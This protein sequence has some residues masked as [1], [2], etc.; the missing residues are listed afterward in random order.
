ML[1]KLSTLLLLLTFCALTYAQDGYK[2]S[3]KLDNYDQKELYLGYYFGDKQY[4]RDTVTANADGAFVF[5]NKTEKLDAGMYLVVMAPDNKYF[6][7]MVNEF[8]QHFSVKT[9]AKNP[10]EKMEIRGS[11][12]NK[13]FYDYLTYLGEQRPIAETLNK[14]IAEATDENVKKGI[15]AKLEQ[16]NKTVEKYQQDIIDKNPLTLTAALIKVNMSPKVPE[17][18]GEDKEVKRWRW[19]Q[20][21]YFDQLDL[22]DERMIRT[23]FLFQRVNNYVEKMVIQNPDTIYQAVDMILQKVQPA[24]PTFKFFLVHFLNKYASAKIVGMDAVYVK[25]AQDYYAKG[26]APW[27]EEEQLTKIVDNAN[28]LEP[29]LIGK[30]APDFKAFE[31]DIPATLKA[32]ET[33]TSEHKKFKLSGERTLHGVESPYTVLVFWASDCGHCKKAM[34]GLK[35]FYDEYKTKGIEM[36][37]VCTK[38]YKDVPECAKLLDENK[39]YDWINIVDPYM[40]SKMTKTY[41]VR[42]TPQ[43]YILDKDKEII[44]KRIGTEQLPEVI[45]QILKQEEEKA[46][47]GK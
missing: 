33:E 22:A 31:L 24:E 15:Q 18:T 37:M 20:K 2:I 35:A 29:L 8:E 40:R 42:S 1:K 13:L 44:S 25:I 3:I 11:K 23:P 12:D 45:D 21:R 16:V 19:M 39:T 26:L 38:T 43:I 34:P 32:I 46:A 41:D 17:F 4:L 10:N 14:G 30:T 47:T 5:E 6:Q 27:T 36:F 7:L 9:D 28:T